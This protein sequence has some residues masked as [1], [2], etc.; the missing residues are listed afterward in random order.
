ML[1]QKF[2]GFGPVAVNNVARSHLSLVPAQFTTRQAQMGVALVGLAWCL[3]PLVLSLYND[4]AYLL[5]V[6]FLPIQDKVMFCMF[7]LN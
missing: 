6:V 7:T 2:G 3:V 4:V 5:Y 1:S